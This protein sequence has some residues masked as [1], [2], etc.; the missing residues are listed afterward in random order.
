MTPRSA[1]NPAF[2]ASW[3]K[4]DIDAAL[5]GWS[6]Q[7][8]AIKQSTRAAFSAMRAEKEARR[9]LE[10]EKAAA[11]AWCRANGNPHIDLMAEKAVLAGPCDC[12]VG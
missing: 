7:S 6:A 3:S 2:P 9:K 8:A 1:Y 10:T 12:E 4:S 11:L 5:D